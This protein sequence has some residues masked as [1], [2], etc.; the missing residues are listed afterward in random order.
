MNPVP[1]PI[2]AKNLSALHHQGIKHGFFTRQ[3]GV[4]KAFTKALMLDKAQMIILN[5]LHKTAL[6]SLIILMLRRKI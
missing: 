4:S 2:L 5:I 6:W 3:G 1:V